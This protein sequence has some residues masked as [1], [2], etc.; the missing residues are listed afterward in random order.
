LSI[1]NKKI[2]KNLTLKI[3]KMKTKLLLFASALFLFWSCEDGLTADV[4]TD[5]ESEVDVTT[6]ADPG[7]TKAG[8]Y[9]FDE[10]VTI[11]FNDNEDLKEYMDKLEGL[12]F[13]GAS[14]TFIDIPEGAGV[15]SVTVELIDY[16]ITARFESITNNL[17]I[18]WTSA[19]VEALNG[20]ATQI[21]AAKKVRVHYSGVASGEFT[22]KLKTTFPA[23]VTAGL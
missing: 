22:F 10:V 19:T 8:T 4:Q 21:I 1:L 13:R 23:T 3:E 14:F 7:T 9:I 2:E 6:V 11:D 17:A 18:A 12:E 15:A 5:L 20:V 16:S